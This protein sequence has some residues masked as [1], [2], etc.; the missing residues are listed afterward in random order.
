M[1]LEVIRLAYAW[2]TAGALDEWT[3]VN[4]TVWSGAT[5]VLW[6]LHQ[7]TV[8]HRR[9]DRTREVSSRCCSRIAGQTGRSPLP[10]VPLLCRINNH[11]WPRVCLTYC[12]ALAIQTTVVSASIS[13]ETSFS[14][15]TNSP[16]AQ[17]E[18]ETKR[19][20]SPHTR[21]EAFHFGLV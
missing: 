17:L 20:S 15:L 5:L 3:N 7:V 18:Q 11:N 12:C 1:I 14:R 8:E 4:G 2:N 16:L 19:A 6:Y 10:L 13:P 21:S 9:T